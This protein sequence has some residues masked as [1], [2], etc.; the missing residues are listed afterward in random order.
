MKILMIAMRDKFGLYAHTYHLIKELSIMSEIDLHVINLIDDN[1]ETT[2]IDKFSNFTIH[3][4]SQNK[5]KFGFIRG[6]LDIIS[7]RKK[8]LDV[9]PEILHIQYGPHL[10]IINI[11]LKNKYPIIFTI[12]SIYAIDEKMFEWVSISRYIYRKILSIVERM[13]I[14]KSLTNIIVAAPPMRDI[15]INKTKAKIY[16]IPNG[17]DLK[18]VRDITS[19]SIGHPCILYVG[20]L[21][22]RKGVDILLKAIPMIKDL[23]PNILLYIIGEGPQDNELKEIVKDLNIDNNVKFLGF[24]SEEEKYSYYKH[25]DICIIPSIDEPFG[26]V[27]LEAMA[28]GKPIVASNVGGIPFVVE[29]GKTGILVKPGDVDILAEKIIMLLQSEELREQ[30]GMA[31]KEKTANFSWQVIAEQTVKIYKDLINRH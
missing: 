25:V 27:L 15:L 20:R 17:I 6:L 22:K 16:I 7:I 13:M 23:I 2:I 5:N 26:I 4:I 30:M 8:I 12:H 31:G 3:Y 11:L 10:S 28:C 18:Y 19:K 29:D 9:N 21:T 14:L 24:V 1:D